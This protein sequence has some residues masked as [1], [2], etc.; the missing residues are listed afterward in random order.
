MILPPL[1]LYNTLSRRKEEFLPLVPGQAGLYSCGPT[2][3]DYA[4]IGN[5][6]SFLLSDLVRRVLESNE[7][8]VR[9]VINITDVGHLTGDGDDGEDKVEM[10]A[11]NKGL[12][13]EM[14]TEKYES[15]FFDDLKALN[16][17][18]AGTEFPRASK[19]IEEQ[20]DLIKK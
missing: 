8:A 5:M 14:V 4:H 15:A 20:I 6:R 17:K 19:H 10:A 7:Y 12:T 13:T 9:Q 2:V 16:I 11:R 1:Y 3:Y 18:T